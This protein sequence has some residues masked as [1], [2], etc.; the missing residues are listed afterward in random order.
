[1]FLYPAKRERKNIQEYFLKKTRLKKHQ[2]IIRH[3]PIG[4]NRPENEK[5]YP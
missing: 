3:N 4:K 2:P 5:K 1:M